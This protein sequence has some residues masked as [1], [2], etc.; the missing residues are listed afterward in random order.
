MNDYGAN[1]SA[2]SAENNADEGSSIAPFKTKLFICSALKK[3]VH[4]KRGVRLPNRIKT[5]CR[6]RAF[7]QMA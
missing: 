2:T 5:A 6:C 1:L 7:Y 4:P 3:S